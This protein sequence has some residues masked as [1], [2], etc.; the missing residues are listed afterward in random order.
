MRSPR[1]PTLGHARRGNRRRPDVAIEVEE[2]ARR[3]YLEFVDQMVLHHTEEAAAFFRKMA[4]LERHHAERLRRRGAARVDNEPSPPPGIFQLVDV[5]AP[6]YERVRAFMTVQRAVEVALEAERKAYR[7][8]DEAARQ[9]DDEEL[10]T[11]FENLRVEEERHQRLVDQFRTTL[12]AEDE[13]DPDNHVD[14]PRA[15]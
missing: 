5:E 7:F 13:A 14:D 3:R 2:E 9:A 11:L 12:P 8:Y 10:R 6:E 4:E 1:L 15:L